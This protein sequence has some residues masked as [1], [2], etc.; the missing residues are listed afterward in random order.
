MIAYESVTIRQYA[1][2][3]GTAISELIPLAEAARGF[4]LLGEGPS[5]RVQ[6]LDEAIGV[7]RFL[8]AGKVFDGLRRHV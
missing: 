3:L 8:Y 6:R 2:A 7:L 5:E 1:D 4:P